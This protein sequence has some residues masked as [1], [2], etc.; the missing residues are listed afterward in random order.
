MQALSPSE[1]EKPREGDGGNQ[2]VHRGATVFLARRSA[3]LKAGAT[4]HRLRRLAAL[5]PSAHRSLRRA[6]TPRE[7]GGPAELVP[8]RV[9]F[10]AAR[11][12]DVEDDDRPAHA[13][14]DGNLLR[15]PLRDQAII[16]RLQHRVVPG[17]SSH[18]GHVEQIA[19]P[20]PPALDMALAAT[21]AAVVIIGSRT[22]QRCGGIV[23]RLT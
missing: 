8:G 23:A 18:A 21:F 3:G 6:C 15:S 5:T 7:P 17:R 2:L 12:L 19:D 22:Q 11:D 1:A 20:A 14:N 13:G 4:R 16:E 10:L 9:P